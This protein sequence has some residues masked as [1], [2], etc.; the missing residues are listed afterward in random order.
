VEELLKNTQ[1]IFWAAVTLIVA[2]PV[3]PF[4]FAL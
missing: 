4:A 2:V 1:L 3:I